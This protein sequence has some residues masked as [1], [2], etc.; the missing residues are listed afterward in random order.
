MKLAPWFKSIFSRSSRR[1][2]SSRRSCHHKVTLRRD[3]ERNSNQPLPAWIEILET[4][5]LLAASFGG[6]N[7]IQTLASEFFGRL[8]GGN[9]LDSYTSPDYQ[10]V[11]LRN[12]RDATH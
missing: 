11:S 4:R 7:T 9:R 8:L 12:Q 5:V 3:F 10:H 1:I 2:R 6:E